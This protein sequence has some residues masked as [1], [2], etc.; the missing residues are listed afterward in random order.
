VQY[1]EATQEEVAV[2]P[3][4]EELMAKVEGINEQSSVRDVKELLE[5]KRKTAADVTFLLED[6]HRCAPGRRCASTAG[7]DS[8]TGPGL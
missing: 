8:R 5:R 7:R 2:N 4:H 3:V 6:D 1:E